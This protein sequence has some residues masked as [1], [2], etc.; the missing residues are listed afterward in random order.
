MSF[1]VSVTSQRPSINSE[2][3]GIKEGLVQQN[4][5]IS[6]AY[7]ETWWLPSKS[8][9][10]TVENDLTKDSGTL[11]AP[12]RSKAAQTKVHFIDI[13]LYIRFKQ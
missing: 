6:L 11:R 4:E 5:V 13:N 2:E 8:M 10:V 12:T 3:K 1:T 9:K 7:D